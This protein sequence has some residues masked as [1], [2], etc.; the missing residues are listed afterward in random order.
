M[1]EVPGAVNEDLSES[2]DDGASNNQNDVVAT[3]DDGGNTENMMGVSESV[4]L[5]PEAKIMEALQCGQETLS[6]PLHHSSFHSAGIFLSSS[7]ISNDEAYSSKSNSCSLF[8]NSMEEEVPLTDQRGRSESKDEMNF[9]F[10]DTPILLNEVTKAESWTDNA[11]C[12]QC[13]PDSDRTQSLHNVKRA[14]SKTSDRA[15]FDLGESLIS[16]DQEINSEI[17]SLYSRSSSCVSEVNMMDTLRGCTFPEPGNGH[18]FSQHASPESQLQDPSSFKEAFFYPDELCVAENNPDNAKSS[19][20]SAEINLIELLDSDQRVAS[21][22]QDGTN[23]GFED[24]YIP[25]QGATSE[26]RFKKLGYEHITDA[27]M[28]ETLQG[29]EILSSKILHDGSIAGTS[30]FLDGGNS[31]ENS[32]NNSG[33]SM[34]T[35]INTEV[36]LDLQEGLFKPQDETAMVSISQY[37]VDSAETNCSN[38]TYTEETMA[39]AVQRVNKPPSHSQDEH[40]GTCISLDKGNNATIYSDYSGSSSS[41]PNDDLIKIQV[42]GPEGSFEPNDGHPPSIEETSISE[43]SSS[44]PTSASHTSMNQ[45]VRSYVKGLPDPLREDIDRF[46]KIPGDEKANTPNENGLSCKKI[47]ITQADVN[48]TESQDCTEASN[49][50]C[51]E[52][53]QSVNEG[54]FRARTSRGARIGA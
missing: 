19:L 22:Q 26:N 2:Q 4:Q 33:S 18:D 11:G 51:P 28:A 7:E 15:N 31:A 47:A 30:A 24:I 53:S 12:S 44:D 42:A 9:A 32:S 29:A 38:H 48:Y 25:R 49:L 46:N 17:F 52:A 23:L 50:N 5:I 8:I 16:P 21:Q 36:I 43:N 35:E 6:D 34:H 3:S 45:S 27:N 1:T 14:P 40:P 39:G 13:I 37:E 41:M 20:C 10:L 54:F